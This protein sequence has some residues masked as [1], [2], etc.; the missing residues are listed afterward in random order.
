MRT[1]YF[2]DKDSRDQFLIELK[3]R[4][5]NFNVEG[6][7]G[8]R[9]FKF[10]EKKMDGK[11]RLFQ[12]VLAA[13]ATFF[14]LGIALTSK[15]IPEL[16]EQA[17]QG[18]KV[19][20]VSYPSTLENRVSQTFQD[21][22]AVSKGGP[23]SDQ[24]PSVETPPKSSSIAGR[25]FRMNPL[26][27]GEVDLFFPKKLPSESS[28][29]YR[30]RSL[31]RTLDEE[32]LQFLFSRMDGERFLALSD[33]Q[34]SSPFFS[35]A[36]RDLDVKGKKERLKEIFPL[37]PNDPLNPLDPIN[38][39]SKRRLQLLSGRGLT[40][41][42]PFFDKE[43]FNLLL[44][45]QLREINFNSSS[46]RDEFCSLFMPESGSIAEKRKSSRLKELSSDQQVALITA[47]PSF[48]GLPHR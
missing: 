10:Y 33:N 15:K 1:F 45:E 24:L 5:Y 6:D 14:S 7:H 26:Q 18:K 44:E 22:T 3:S 41:I 38:Q 39:E 17:F 13:L 23:S 11:T 43:R 40:E 42:I 29:E 32:N 47:F 25:R 37:N 48:T 16:W 35:T 27:E 30:E 28:Q 34:I 31:L 36:F 4:N 2:A 8:G 19:I 9:H 20:Q 12:G 46:L 21:S